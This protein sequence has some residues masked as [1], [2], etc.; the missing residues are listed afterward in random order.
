M[1]LTEL[2]YLTVVS[3][4]DQGLEPVLISTSAIGQIYCTNYFNGGNYMDNCFS[5]L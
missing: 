3:S 1:R 5:H 2:I 4:D